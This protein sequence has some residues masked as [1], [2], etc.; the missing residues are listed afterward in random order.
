MADPLNVGSSRFW[1]KTKGF[2]C[3]WLLSITH[4][5][6]KTKTIVFLKKTRIKDILKAVIYL[7]KLYHA[8]VYL[9]KIDRH[10]MLKFN[11]FFFN[12]LLKKK[13]GELSYSTNKL[14]YV[15][16]Y[17]AFKLLVFLWHGWN[18]DE[19]EVKLGVWAMLRGSLEGEGGATVI[20][21]SSLDVERWGPWS[22]ASTL[23]DN[24]LKK[25]YQSTELGNLPVF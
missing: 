7:L 18:L 8:E 3:T 6:K 14:I 25:K 12:P 20:C 19:V 21:T 1:W 17:L 16:S 13:I 10:L 5:T 22:G 24:L 9:S 15:W 4:K 23:N 2:L 11:R